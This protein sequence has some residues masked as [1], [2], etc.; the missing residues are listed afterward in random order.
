MTTPR[1]RPEQVT[2]P[3]EKRGRVLLRDATKDPADVPSA[4]EGDDTTTSEIKSIV[5]RQRT[6]YTWWSEVQETVT[7]TTSAAVKSLP[8]VVLVDLPEDA[9]IERVI[10]LFKFRQVEDTSA[11]LNDLNIACGS[12]IEIRETGGTFLDAIDLVDQQFQVP[13]SERGPGDVLIGDIDLTCELNGNT[14]YNFQF[15]SIA[16]TG[17]SLI[18][19]DVQCGIQVMWG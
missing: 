19:R 1:G 8:N 9:I 6:V 18:L 7:F 5:A 17:S 15:A 3:A 11:T 16:S 10:G 13:A 12:D 2:R 4:A 14:T